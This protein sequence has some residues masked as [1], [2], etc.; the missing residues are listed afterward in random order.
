MLEEIQKTFA[1]IPGLEEV[2]VNHETGSVV[3]RYDADRHHDFH[4]GFTHRFN[5]PASGPSTTT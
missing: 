2:V 5:E 4:A 1:A 3:L